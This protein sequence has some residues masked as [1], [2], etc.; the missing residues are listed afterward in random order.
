M[1]ES[2]PGDTVPLAGQGRACERIT[3][4]RKVQRAGLGTCD[5]SESYFE[6]KHNFKEKYIGFLG[7]GRLGSA[8]AQ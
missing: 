4:D 1:S 8:A 5:S 3:Q 2:R 7:P 6:T